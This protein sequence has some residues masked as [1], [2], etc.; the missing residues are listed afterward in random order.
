MVLSAFGCGAFR[1]PPEIVARL[2]RMELAR[3]PLR[4]AVFCIRDDHNAGRW[5]NLKGNL[6][7]FQELFGP[8][9]QTISLLISDLIPN[10][11]KRKRREEL[12][13]PFLVYMCFLDVFF[14]MPSSGE[15]GGAA[16]TISLLISHSILNKT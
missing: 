3:S 15:R 11:K 5:H 2:F 4:L 7:P 9:P 16:Q 1:N 12:P 10:K 8:A 14:Y 13:G 6:R